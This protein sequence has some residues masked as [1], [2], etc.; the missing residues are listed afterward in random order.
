MENTNKLT[1]NKALD[2]AIAKQMELEK[3]VATLQAQ[4]AAKDNTKLTLGM[5]EYSAGTF[6]IRGLS[7]FGL[8]LYP[9]Q[10]NKLKTLVQSG[11]IDKYITD[12]SDEF[13]VARV[14]SEYAAKLGKKWPQGRSKTDPDAVAFMAAYEAGKKIAQADKSIDVT[15]K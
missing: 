10:Y 14:A 13:R 6:T 15:R 9:E 2:E 1:G 5:S 3:Q 8:S 4:L 11:E 12:H 7:R